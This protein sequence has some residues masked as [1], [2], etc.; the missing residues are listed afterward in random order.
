MHEMEM[1]PGKRFNRYHEFGQFAFGKKLGLYIVVLQQL[2]VEVGVD[3]VYMVTGGKSLKKGPG[4]VVFVL[5]WIITLY[6]VE[7]HEMVPE[8]RFNRVKP[9]PKQAHPSLRPLQQHH[10]GPA[11]AATFDPSPFTDCFRYLLQVFASRTRMPP[12][13]TPQEEEIEPSTMDVEFQIPTEASTHSSHSTINQRED[14]R[15][16]ETAKICML[17]QFSGILFLLEIGFMAKL[18]ASWLVYP[19]GVSCSTADRVPHWLSTASQV[20][21]FSA[22]SIPP[23]WVRALVSGVGPCLFCSYKLWPGSSQTLIGPGQADALTPTSLA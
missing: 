1:V 15:P 2:I 20:S 19:P 6:L 7:M 11:E 17:V 10:V 3:I 5:S 9:W 13:T 21:S 4:I 12:A 8:K 22:L 23:G 14:R 18:P 16:L